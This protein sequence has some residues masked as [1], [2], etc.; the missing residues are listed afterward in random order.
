[1]KFALTDKHFKEI[2]E[3]ITQLKETDLKELKDEGSKTL[4][5]MYDALSI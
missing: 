5:Q 1:M 2:E 3:S 4:A